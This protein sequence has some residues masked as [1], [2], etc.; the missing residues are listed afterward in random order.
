M[1]GA[2]AVRPQAG[3]IETGIDA[4]GQ[5]DGDSL[6]LEPFRRI[7]DEA[8][9][10]LHSHQVL[11]PCR[12]EDELLVQPLE[13]MHAEANLEGFYLLP[14]GTRRDVQ[15]ARSERKAQVARRGFECAQRVQRWQQIGH[16]L[17]HYASIVWQACNRFSIARMESAFLWQWCSLI[18][19]RAR[20][21]TLRIC[22]GSITSLPR[23][24]GRYCPSSSRWL[25]GVQSTIRR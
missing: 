5:D 3:E 1:G 22:D 10:L 11:L 9:T 17:D 6:R 14:D 4:Y 12:S 19:L 21:E 18:G 13:K 25:I 20:R 15:L 16:G 2:E 7:P 24:V 23:P 8:K